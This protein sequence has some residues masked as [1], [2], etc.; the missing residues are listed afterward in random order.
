M[1]LESVQVLPSKIFP[2][3]SCSGNING[4]EKMWTNISINYVR[5][6]PYTWSYWALP[7]TRRVSW[8]HPCIKRMNVQWK[9]GQV[10]RSPPL[11]IAAA[12][13]A[14]H[15]CQRQPSA[16]EREKRGREG[17]YGRGEGREEGGGGR[18]RW[19]RQNRYWALHLLPLIPVRVPIPIELCSLWILVSVHHLSAFVNTAMLSYGSPPLRRV[20]VLPR[21]EF[22]HA[23][24]P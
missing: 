1:K 11:Y 4:K 21:R 13:R 15:P 24:D 19:P 23:S 22:L 6:R 16:L 18:R 10:Q 7:R 14:H 9:A 3:H 17:T 8:G 2:F 20:P 12:H 5:V